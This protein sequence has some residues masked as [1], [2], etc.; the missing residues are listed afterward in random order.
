MTKRFFSC[1]LPLPRSLSTRLNASPS[2]YLSARDQ[3]H[4]SR[5]QAASKQG[6]A[7]SAA[8]RPPAPTLS[9][10]QCTV[11]AAS[12]LGDRVLQNISTIHRRKPSSPGA[13]PPALPSSILRRVFSSGRPRSR[14]CARSK[15]RC[16]RQANRKVGIISIQP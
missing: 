12:P 9:E 14:S 6:A 7:S 11:T 13:V 10:V 1:C 3:Y 15:S 16:I 8:D 4:G 2:G 5:A